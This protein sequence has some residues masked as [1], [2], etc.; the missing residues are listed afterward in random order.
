MHLYAN[1]C[2]CK[3]NTHITVDHF[4][5]YIIQVTFRSVLANLTHSPFFY[6]IGPNEAFFHAV[7]LKLL[8]KNNWK[9]VGILSSSGTSSVVCKIF[10]SDHM[11]KV[12]ISCSHV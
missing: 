3:Y 6:R 1:M 7:G 12:F 8:I 9:R 5:S 2:M 4:V 10:V 11:L